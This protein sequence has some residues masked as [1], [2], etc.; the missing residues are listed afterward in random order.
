MGIRAIAVYSEAP[1]PVLPYTWGV[2][3]FFAARPRPPAGEHHRLD[4]LAACSMA[5]CEPVPTPLLDD[6]YEA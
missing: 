6:Y 3:R 1:T 4:A 5:A 2:R